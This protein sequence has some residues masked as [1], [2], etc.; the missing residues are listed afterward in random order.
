LSATWKCRLERDDAYAVV[1]PVEALLVRLSPPQRTQ[2][3]PVI[4]DEAAFWRND[5]DS[6]NPDVEILN[7][8]RPGL[9][10]TNGPP[11]L[12]SSPYGRCG[13]LCRQFKQYYGPDGDPSIL[14]AKGASRDLNPSLS[15]SVVDRA[16]ERDPTSARA[17]FLAEFRTHIERFISRE[18]VEAATP[19]GRFELPPLPDV[20]YVGFV[21]PQEDQGTQ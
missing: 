20:H 7:S 1:F 10:T 3:L 21:D 2:Y 14:V 17:E 4:G 12:I 13:E 19:P 5:T 16:L 8:F 9:S 15:Q 18:I 6:S 11:I